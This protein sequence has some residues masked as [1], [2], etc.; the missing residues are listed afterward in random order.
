MISFLGKKDKQINGKPTRYNETTQ[1]L[2]SYKTNI[3]KID[4]PSSDNKMSTSIMKNT[5]FIMEKQKP[6]IP[7][8]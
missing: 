8:T 3:L 1:K 5:P 6:E 2:D 7:R 4:F